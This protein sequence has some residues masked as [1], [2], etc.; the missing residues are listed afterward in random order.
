LDKISYLVAVTIYHFACRFGS[1]PGNHT[2]W[3]V[4]ENLCAPG[5]FN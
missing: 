1:Q 3:P 2:I 5:G 4:D